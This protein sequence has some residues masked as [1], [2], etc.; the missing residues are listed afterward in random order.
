MDFLEAVG[1]HLVADFVWLT[2]VSLVVA[3]GLFRIAAWPVAVMAVRRKSPV[4]FSASALLRVRSG[5][6]YL[7]TITEA[8]GE[9]PAYWAPLG[10]VI[11]CRS[12]ALKNLY[13][14]EVQTD[15]LPE[16]H[17]DMERDLRVKMR[18]ARFW[19]FMRWYWRSEARE[20]PSEALS[21]ELKEE[22]G[23][24]GLD[25]LIPAIGELEFNVCPVKS[26][27]LFSHGDL[28]HY[29]IFYVI[30][31]TG[32]TADAFERRLLESLIPGKLALISE[33]DIREGRC[34][35]VIVGGHSAFLVPGEKY[36]HLPVSYQ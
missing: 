27:K 10:G 33:S 8:R 25:P 20:S 16:D 29:R 36:E 19:R 24:L 32:A 3:R 18:G 11:K 22:L 2:L 5:S 30:D 4:R 28:F 13:D 21:R 26:T 9:S 7:L 34:R 31:L 23:D 12:E 14:L 1:E 6:A 35:G 15:W 17:D